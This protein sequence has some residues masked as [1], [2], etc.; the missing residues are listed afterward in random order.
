[1]KDWKTIIYNLLAGDSELLTLLEYVEG[2][3]DKKLYYISPD[4]DIFDKV[5]C[6]T[7]Q[8]DTDKPALTGDDILKENG[9]EVTFHIWHRETTFEIKSKIVEIIEN[10]TYE[11][12][13]LSGGEF[14]D[15]EG[16]YHGILRY[17]LF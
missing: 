16:L 9:A 7:F 13:L 12:N 8:I 10:S 6:I 3:S 17:E 4:V 5:P 15:P 11:S 1:M 14:K 2:K